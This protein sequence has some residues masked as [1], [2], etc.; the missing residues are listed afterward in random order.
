MQGRGEEEVD[1][2]GDAD[3]DADRRGGDAGPSVSLPLFFVLSSSRWLDRDAAG[4]FPWT[5]N[6]VQ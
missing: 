6:A 3:G 4:H 5:S 1:G 2:D